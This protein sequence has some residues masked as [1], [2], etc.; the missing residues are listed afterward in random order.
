[1]QPRMKLFLGLSALALLI[2][3]ALPSRVPDGTASAAAAT[4]PVAALPALPDARPGGA[5][6]HTLGASARGDDAATRQAVVAHLAGLAWG[7]D[8]FLPPDRVHVYVEP[9]P[10]PA[11]VVA[12]LALPALSGISRRGSSAMAILDESIVEPGDRIGGGF[13]V[14]AI[15]AGAVTL[16]RDGEQ[17]I[18]TLSEG[19]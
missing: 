13:V 6:Q 15:E 19:R 5:V 9:D 4:L 7:R 2:V 18:L 16:L 1:M 17:H 8:P 11:P 3:V 14:L 10:A 12:D